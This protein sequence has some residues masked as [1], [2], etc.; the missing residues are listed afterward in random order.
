MEHT[1]EAYDQSHRVLR[2][3]DTGVVAELLQP[4]P[5]GSCH[6]LVKREWCLRLEVVHRDVDVHLATEAA[7]SS[8]LSDLLLQRAQVTRYMDID[9]RILA[10]HGVDLHGDLLSLTALLRPPVAGH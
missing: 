5:V 2:Q 3:R 8:P 9:I 10:I 7:R 6:L 4:L 1:L